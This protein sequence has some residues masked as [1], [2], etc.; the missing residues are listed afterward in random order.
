M[1]ASGE[2]HFWVYGIYFGKRIVYVGSTSDPERRF[3]EHFNKSC[4]MQSNANNRLYALINYAMARGVFP[5]FKIL[6]VEYYHNR[7]GDIADK[8]RD[9]LVNSSTRGV[10]YTEERGVLYN[11]EIAD[12]YYY[13]RVNTRKQI[14]FIQPNMEITVKQLADKRKISKVYILRLLRNNK[15]ELLAAMGVKSWRMIG[16]SYV[17]KM[18]KDF[19]LPENNS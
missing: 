13:M 2:Y 1:A 18:D 15:A 9:K 19:T 5:K 6:H 16:S 11:E 17:L 12:A 3:R 7:E 4:N 14:S 10:F 8:Y